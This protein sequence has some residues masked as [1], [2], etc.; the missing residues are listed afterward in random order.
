MVFRWNQLLLFQRS[1][2]MA[3][4]SS[5]PT[6]TIA[7]NIMFDCHIY[8]WNRCGRASPNG[9]SQHHRYSILSFITAIICVLT[10]NLDLPCGFACCIYGGFTYGRVN[11]GYLVLFLAYTLAVI[12]ALLVFLQ[13]TTFPLPLPPPRMPLSV[14]IGDGGVKDQEFVETKYHEEVFVG[15]AS[16]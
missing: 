14:V 11:I 3:I 16:A 7:I 15:G 2:I 6:C 5:V 13:S 9:S 1:I 4:S 12:M 8:K 10:N